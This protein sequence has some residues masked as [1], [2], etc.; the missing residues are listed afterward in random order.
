[1]AQ[2]VK[3]L[4]AMQETQ[5]PSL[6]QE[7]SLEKKMATYSSIPVWRIP[8]MEKTG[9]LHTVHGVAKSWTRLSNFTF[10]LLRIKA[11]KILER[12]INRDYL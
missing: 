2:M 4:A 7:D 9:R 3:T 5:V 10:H 1:M 11:P 8:W 12:I 6:G